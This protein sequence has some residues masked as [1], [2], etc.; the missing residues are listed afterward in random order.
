M[1][2]LE[3]PANC[4][5]ELTENEMMMY[6]EGGG[7]VIWEILKMIIENWPDIKQGFTDGYNAVEN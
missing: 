6:G 4:Y 2:T 3:I 5:R 1:I 7:G